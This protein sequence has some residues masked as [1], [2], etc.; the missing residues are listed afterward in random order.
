MMTKAATGQASAEDA[1][2][3]A[4]QRCEAIF[5]KWARRT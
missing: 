4:A 5:K 1:V 2:K 3:E